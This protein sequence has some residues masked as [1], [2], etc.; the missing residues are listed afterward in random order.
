MLKTFRKYTA[1]GVVLYSMT[2]INN[3]VY[4][5]GFPTVDIA[6]ITQQIVQYG[7]SL[8]ELE[9]MIEQG[10]DLKEQLEQE[11][12][13]FDTFLS[14]LE[15]IEDAFTDE[16]WQTIWDLVQSTGYHYEYGY[17]SAATIAEMD[18]SDPAYESNVDGMISQTR[19][20]PI[21]P[22]EIY[23]EALQ[24][25]YSEQEAEDMR[26]LQA[27]AYNAH[28]N[29]KDMYRAVSKVEQDAVKRR[30]DLLIQKAKTSQLKSG[31]TFVSDQLRNQQLSLIAE[32]NEQIIYQLNNL[33]MKPDG[34][35][36]EMQAR[37]AK[38]QEELMRHR[39]RMAERSAKWAEV[40]AA[41]DG[42]KWAF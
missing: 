14:S 22:D 31:Q 4:A 32:Q 5:S 11:K 30:E 9:E 35:L 12:L 3:N 21:H 19:H 13:H 26:I 27:E 8:Q 15:S 16:Q 1:I 41:V 18:I 25:G 2:S 17:G 23:A 37:K 6:S 20:V 42:S 39:Q 7:E 38:E 10:I 33:L 28:M 24:M 29:Q 34:I 40:R 36:V